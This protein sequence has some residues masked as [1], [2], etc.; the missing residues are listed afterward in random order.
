MF[1]CLSRKGCLDEQFEA[2]NASETYF[3]VWSALLSGCAKAR[4]TAMAEHVFTE[5]Q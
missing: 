5:M 1:D 4:D 3:A 2:E